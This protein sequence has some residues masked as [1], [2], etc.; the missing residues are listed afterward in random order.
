[1]RELSKEEPE[2][3]RERTPEDLPEE[4][5]EQWVQR[6]IPKG[7]RGVSRI[8]PTGLG[9]YQNRLTQER[10]EWVGGG[11]ARGRRRGGGRGGERGRG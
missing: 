3:W 4:C 2:T 1:M 5:K 6:S 8:L 7:T 10:G 11:R 9:L